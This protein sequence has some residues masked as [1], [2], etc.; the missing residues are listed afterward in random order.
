MLSNSNALAM[1]AASLVWA[2]NI[3]PTRDANGNEILPDRDAVVD[4]GLAV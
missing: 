4:E 3:K 2:F 1:N